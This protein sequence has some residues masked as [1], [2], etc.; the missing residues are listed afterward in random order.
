MET[1]VSNAAFRS[2]V[3]G[4]ISEIWPWGDNQRSCIGTRYGDGPE[5]ALRAVR[6]TIRVV[7]EFSFSS[8][9]PGSVVQF[10]VG[11]SWIYCAVTALSALSHFWPLS[12]VQSG[13][14]TVWIARS[15]RARV[16]MIARNRSDLIVRSR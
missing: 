13:D 11:S 6:T 1:V 9:S 8:H 12:V 14:G 16:E 15:K 2:R 4:S 7:R 5:L 10:S 3:G